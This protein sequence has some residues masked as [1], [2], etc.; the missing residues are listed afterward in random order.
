[1]DGKSLEAD[2]KRKEEVTLRKLIALLVIIAMA[3]VGMAG[4]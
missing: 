4:A 3:V 2:K 1:V